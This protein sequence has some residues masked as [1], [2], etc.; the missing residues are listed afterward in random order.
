MSGYSVA[1]LSAVNPDAWEQ[2]CYAVVVNRNGQGCVL[3]YGGGASL[4]YEIEEMGCNALDDL[5]LDDAPDGISVWVG[6]YIT[7]GGAARLGDYDDSY[8]TKAVGEFR[9]PTD[10]EWAAIRQQK[11]PWP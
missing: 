7:V 11:N 2:D 6:R 3:H 8:E 10:E 4:R 1:K 9:D 5:G